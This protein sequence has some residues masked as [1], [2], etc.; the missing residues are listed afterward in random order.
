MIL[1]WSRL[2]YEEKEEK[3][4]GDVHKFASGDPIYLKRSLTT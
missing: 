1:W 4:L 3:N 2:F